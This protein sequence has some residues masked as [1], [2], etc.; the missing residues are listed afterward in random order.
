[1]TTET[2]VVLTYMLKE[3]RCATFREAV[4]EIVRRIRAEG[5]ISVMVLDTIWIEERKGHPI[6]F[7]DILER[8][9]NEGILNPDGSIA[10]GQEGKPCS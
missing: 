4:V 9:H 8:A 6:F 2:P 10:E 1:M 3:T 5:S 7:L